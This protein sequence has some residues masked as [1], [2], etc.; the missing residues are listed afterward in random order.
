MP[1]VNA[2][3]IARLQAAGSVGDRIA[4]YLHMQPTEP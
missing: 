2:D 3:S 4:H 1:P